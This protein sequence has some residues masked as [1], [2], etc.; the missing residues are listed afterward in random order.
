VQVRQGPVPLVTL[1]LKPRI[2][3]KAKSGPVR[4]LPVEQELAVLPAAQP[5]LDEL[6]IEEGTV[7]NDVQYHYFLNLPSLGVR[8]HFESPVIKGRDEYVVKI[9]NGIG[10]AWAGTGPNQVAAFETDLKSIGAM[11][12]AELM[13]REMQELLWDLR[14]RIK[15]VQVFSMEPFIPW[16]LLYLKDPRAEVL[17]DKSSFLGELGLVR[18]LY[19]GFPPLTVTLREGRARY[20]IP[21]YL[22]K[23]KLPL[24]REEELMVQ[25]LFNA[26]SVAARAVDVQKLVRTPGSFD[27]LHFA[28]HAEAAGADQPDAC[29]LLDQMSDDSTENVLKATTVAQTAR[30]DDNGRRPIVVLN[31]CES[32]RG[33]RSFEGIGG[34]ASAFVSRGAGVFIGTHWSVGEGPARTFIESFYK[35]L[36]ASGAD[37]KGVRLLDAVS[38]ARKAARKKGDAT[39]LAYV[40]YGHP[41]ATF[42][43]SS[44]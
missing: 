15:S 23:M 14:A 37:G 30:L 6:L 26:T 24:A 7:G 31:A 16:E 18:W 38:K 25:K 12:F 5:P 2:V 35:S 8:K 3:R 19:D 43:R 40:V 10:A 4:R 39:W 32:G 34:F 28:G 41:M 29:L 44:K 27:L 17:S 9:L 20:V 11:M 36:S 1:K 42:V 13:P 21:T 33:S 22:G